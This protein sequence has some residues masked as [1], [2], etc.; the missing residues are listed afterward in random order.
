MMLSLIIYVLLCAI[1]FLISLGGLRETVKE[2]K[3]D[4]VDVIAATFLTI[5]GPVGTIILI[6]VGIV[7][8]LNKKHGYKT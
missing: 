8:Y 1:N 7:T 6:I 2:T 4:I 5:S 3:L